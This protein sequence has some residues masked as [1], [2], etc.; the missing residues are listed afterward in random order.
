MH[1]VCVAVCVLTVCGRQCG[2][3]G[4]VCNGACGKEVVYGIVQCD[5]KINL[6]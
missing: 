6:A 1:C 4:G 5:S 2:S 3:V